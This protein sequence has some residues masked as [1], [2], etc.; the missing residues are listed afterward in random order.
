M[1]IWMMYGL[2]ALPVRDNTVQGSFYL[3]TIDPYTLR[4][5]ASASTTRS[6]F[7]DTPSGSSL[8]AGRGSCTPAVDPGTRS[9]APSRP[10]VKS[11]KTFAPSTSRS[12]PPSSVLRPP[13]CGPRRN[14]PSAMPSAAARVVRIW[15]ARIAPF[16]FFFFKPICIPTTGQRPTPVAIQ[17]RRIYESM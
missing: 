11:A 5:S 9:V 14:C 13:V 17:N 7:S 2:N 15:P 16:F 3:A 4:R 12:L 6:V 1:C 10:Y 8:S